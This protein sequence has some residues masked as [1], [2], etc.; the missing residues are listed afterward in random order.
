MRL[1]ILGPPGAGK[2]TQAELLSES[3]GIPHISTG[4]LF[5]ANIS[6][7][8]AVGI[9]A[10]RYLDAGDLV[11]SEITVDMVRARVGEPDASKGF[12]LD[13]FPRSTEQADALA[14]ILDGLDSSLDAVLSFVVDPDVV[15][16]RMLARGRA[17]DTEEVIRNRMSVYQ[18]ETAPLLD[19]YGDQVK[20][21]DA[22]GDIQDV[23]QRVLSALG[24]GV[25]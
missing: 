1:V 4:D 11:P 2:G 16:E 14:E 8:T 12:I 24:A 9:E 5:R 19:Y 3:L 23:H 7:G 18:K 15:V 10:K 22:V 17:D 21:I 13:G 25:S 20:T 6:Q